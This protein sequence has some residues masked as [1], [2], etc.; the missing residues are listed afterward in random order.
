[1]ATW[2]RSCPQIVDHSERSIR[3]S[4]RWPVLARAEYLIIGLPRQTYLHCII[5]IISLN[6]QVTPHSRLN[7][8]SSVP[9]LIFY[10]SYRAKIRREHCC[11]CDRAIFE[12]HARLPLTE[13]VL[14]LIFIHEFYETSLRVCSRVEFSSGLH[15]ANCVVRHLHWPIA[16]QRFRAGFRV[17]EAGDEI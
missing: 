5:S 13:C 17:I 12:K 9:L 8:Q 15:A 1:M 2:G 11:R 16:V 14:I 6:S 10:R 7:L 4:K 3:P